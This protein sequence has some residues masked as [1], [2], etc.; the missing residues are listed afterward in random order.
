MDSAPVGIPIRLDIDTV[1]PVFSRALARLD[2]ATTQELDSAAIEPLMRELIRM[3]A[4]QLNGCAYCVNLHTNDAVAAGEAI[5]RVAAVS[6]W[7]ESPFF[8]QRERHARSAGPRFRCRMARGCR[9]LHPHGI[10]SDRLVDRHDQCL[11]RRGRH[12]SRLDP[13]TVSAGTGTTQTEQ[14]R[15][16]LAEYFEAWRSRDF[17]RLRHVLHPDVTFVGAMGTANGI[18]Q[19][20]AGLRGMAQ[21]VMTDLVLHARVVEGAD[22]ITWFDLISSDTALPTANWSHVENGLI[23]KIRVTFDP[24]P[25]IA[26]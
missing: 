6:V 22:G 12:H 2:S 11:E 5:G 23:T 7:R 9:T 24:R 13:V 14:T 3:R 26:A 1:A 20:L 10:G 25:L 4:S 19:C 15:A 18:E 8:S 16:V 17:D 21:S